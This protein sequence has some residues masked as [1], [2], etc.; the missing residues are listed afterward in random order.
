[1]NTITQEQLNPKQLERL[2]AQRQLY[3]DAKRLQLIYTILSIPA[4]VVWSI[5]VVNFPNLKIWSAFWGVAVTCLGLFILN[6]H[7]KKLQKKAAKI[8]QMFDCDVLQMNWYKLN[9]GKRIDPELICRKNKEYIRNHTDH[10]K[11]KNWYPTNINRL[12]IHYAR[13]ICQR[14]NCWWDA[15]LRRRYINW[16]LSI[17]IVLSVF[18]FLIGFVN[19]LTLEVVFLAVLLPL[20]PV[21]FFGIN[22]YRDNNDAASRLDSLKEQAESYWQQAINQKLTSDEITQLSY[23][24]QDNIY[25]N[26][27]RNP[28]IFDWIYNCIK[29][30]NEEQMNRG[31]K[32]LIEE[33]Q[34]SIN[35]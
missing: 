9:T 13:L 16:V 28:L 31:A 34:S 24:L 15:Q 35:P 18:V 12:P 11:L 4:V 17:I 27:S 1:M 10:S 30:E 21:L 32:D 29:N 33:L 20:A 26:R 5:L 23:R 2:A 3:S 8:Q 14:T 19:G 25:D 6:P 22:Q 7:Q